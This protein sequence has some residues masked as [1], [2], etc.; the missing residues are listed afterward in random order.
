MAGFTLNIEN[1]AHY[2]SGNEVHFKWVVGVECTPGLV[3]RIVGYNYR[4]LTG[5]SGAGKRC[6]RN[7]VVRA[8]PQRLSTFCR[9]TGATSAQPR[10]PQLA[11]P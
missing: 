5:D 1:T 2:K 11:L 8:R 6:Q 7:Y 3:L 9:L 4:Q 10:S